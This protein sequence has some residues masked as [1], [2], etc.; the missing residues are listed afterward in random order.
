LTPIAGQGEHIIMTR[1]DRCHA[2][3]AALLAGC[4]TLLLIS[5]CTMVGEGPPPSSPEFTQ[6][7][8]DHDNVVTQDEWLKA[9]LAQFDTLD[10]NHDG[11]LDRAE[12][13]AERQ[14]LDRNHDGTV[15]DTEVSQPVSAYDTDQDGSIS[16]EEFRDGLVKDLG[17]T[18]GATSVQRDQVVQEIN[19]RFSQADPNGTGQVTDSSLLH[20]VLYRF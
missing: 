13:E 1:L 2:A 7:D 3:G 4:G 17:G 11:T 10:T 9:G 18:P 16:E 19:R 5:A 15:S 6:A 20:F 14:T 12:I 8:L